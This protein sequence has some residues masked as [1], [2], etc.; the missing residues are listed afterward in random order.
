MND[1]TSPAAPATPPPRLIAWEVTRSC[2]LACRHC[3]A[4]AQAGPYQGEFS[5][6]ECERM[7]SS[8]AASAKPI[9]ILTGGEPLLRA[10]I[11][12]L[13]A[14]GTGLGLRMVLAT[15]G[16][17]LTD[18]KCAE[19][20]D[21][22]VQRLSLSIDGATAESHDGLRGVSGAFDGVMRALETARR[23]GLPFQIN[24]TVTRGNVAQLPAIF[25]LA[26]QQQAVSFHPFLLV[27]TGRGRQLREELLDAQ[28]YE[29]ALEW[30]FE[31]R[32][33]PAMSMK[34]TCAPQYFRLLRQR[35]ADAGPGHGHG[36]H[37]GPG[38]DTLSKGCLGG[39][40]FAFISHTGEV[41]ICGFLELSAGN[42]RDHDFAFE[43][44]WQ[45]SAFLKS[46]RAI[47][48]YH[49]RCGYCEF[50]RVCG[51]CRARAYALSGDYLAEEPACDYQPHTIPTTE[52]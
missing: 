41:Q 44:I 32:N 42:V 31:H 19:L 29:R 15:C 21:A 7:L 40:G 6:A 36:H 17:L 23:C 45:D 34:P 49:G 27:P 46:I 14:F 8:I 13:A 25:E 35:G 3:R 43:R 20:R 47:D 39:Q 30:I 38:L 50:R 4:A 52:N 1:Q 11:G 16:T 22:G 48:T 26:L 2:P 28:E 5:T 9:I 33:H 18:E 24:T 12:H 37:S 51:G 10:D